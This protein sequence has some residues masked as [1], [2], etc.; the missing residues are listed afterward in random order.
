MA[1]RRNAMTVD[2]FGTTVTI[3]FSDG[4]DLSLEASTLTPEIQRIA[5]MQALANKLVD[6]AAIKCNTNTGLPASID[7]KYKAVAE[8]HA[9]LTGDNPTWNKERGTGEKAPKGKELLVRALMQMKGCSKDVIEQ[10]LTTKTKAEVEALKKN[11]RVA[12]IMVELQAAGGT[13]GVDTDA[14]LC[15]LGDDIVPETVEPKAETEAV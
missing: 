6:A 5:M 4:R 15:E 14:L 7:D 12:K 1:T 9:R 10:F 3:T 11:E 8:V 2:I 13:G